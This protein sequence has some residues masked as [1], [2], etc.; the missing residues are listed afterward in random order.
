MKKTDNTGIN[1][2]ERYVID[3]PFVQMG[4]VGLPAQPVVNVNCG[5]LRGRY[6][7]L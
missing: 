4:W 5:P 1:Q 7:E 3:N 6:S 2:F